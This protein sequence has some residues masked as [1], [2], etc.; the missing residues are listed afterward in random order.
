MLKYLTQENSNVSGKR[1]V[2]CVYH[3]NNRNGFT[4]ISQDILNV[5][6]CTVFY[7]DNGHLPSEKETLEA[8]LTAMNLVVMIVSSDLLFAGDTAARALFDLTIKHTV[9]VLPI[10]VESGLEEVFNKKFGNLQCL[11]TFQ[12]NYDST[13]VPY[14]EKLNNYLSQVLSADINARELRS[15]F[16]ACIFLS[17]RK[18]DRS[19]AQRLM[20]LIHEDESCRNIAIWYDEFLTPGEDFNNSI[21]DQLEQSDL[22]VMAIT[23]GTVEGENYIRLVE[24]PMAQSL[25]KSILP[26]EMVPTDAKILQACYPR[27]SSPLEPIGEKIRCAILNALEKMCIKPV[28]SSNERT[29]LIGLAYLNG[30]C[31]EKNNAVGSSM[32]LSAAEAGV[33]EAV[34]KAVTMHQNGEGVEKDLELAEMWQQRLLNIRKTELFNKKG[35]REYFDEVIKVYFELAEIQIQRNDAKA[36]QSTYT[37][38]LDFC[39][40]ESLSEDIALMKNKA[41]ACEKA[42]RLYMEYGDY[43]SARHQLLSVALDIR[44]RLYDTQKTLQS[45]IDLIE[46]YELIAEC[47][48][49]CDDITGLKTNLIYIKEHLSQIDEDVG[50]GADSH[51]L[52]IRLINCCNKI[53]HY[54]NLFKKW[55][56]TAVWAGKA[57]IIAEKLVKVSGSADSEK[58]L[59]NAYIMNGDQ[60]SWCNVENHHKAALESYLSALA[61]ANS[62]ILDKETLENLLSVAQINEKLGFISYKLGHFQQAK[63]YYTVALNRFKTAYTLADT[64]PVKK[65]L[66]EC[67]FGASK[68]CL[69]Q[70]E[71]SEGVNLLLESAKLSLEVVSETKLIVF[72]SDLALIYAALGNYYKKQ[73]DTDTALE[74]YTKRHSLISE[75]WRVSKRVRDLREL[76][77]SYQ[78]LISVQKLAGNFNDARILSTELDSLV[79]RYSYALNSTIP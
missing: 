31:V 36:A 58:Q 48:E 45:E 55:E 51:E 3:P 9:P 72:K 4:R 54:Y 12:E 38:L 37:Q 79:S 33:M 75:V 60:H 70:G 11:C 2:L 39:S 40:E 64:V 14:I 47:C 74:Y 77:A 73:W 50:F 42:A 18:K 46:V 49:C 76:I 53:C 16:D 52:I 63:Q 41:C 59:M 21:K 23:P 61:I 5:C 1:K 15:A 30:I 62:H 7:Y 22:F 27:I 24:Y 68:V 43:L 29:F 28:E 65:K 13:S 20:E 69:D 8:E 25:G 10:L 56:E 78:D 67:Y 34:Q 32:V 35:E 26:V 66:Y 19:F 17:Y 57:L 71:Q 44:Q 6:D